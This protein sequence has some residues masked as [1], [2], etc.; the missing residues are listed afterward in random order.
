MKLFFP[1]VLAVLL[2]A[3]EFDVATIKPSAPG[4]IA[5]SF[6]S[7]PGG[8]LETAGSTLKD[9]MVIAYGDVAAQIQGGPAWAAADRYDVTA[10]V[11]EGEGD[12]AALAP[13]SHQYWSEATRQRTRALLASRFKLTV[14]KETRELPI[15]EL[16]VDKNGP[17]ATLKETDLNL[18]LS[19]RRW[20]EVAGNGA[21]LSGLVSLLSNLVQ[22]PV[23]DKTGLTARYSFTLRWAPDQ[24]STV[25]GAP[26]AEP[27][28]LPSIFTAL[29]E[30]L[31]LRLDSA[32][33]PIEVLVI[34]RAE[35]PSAD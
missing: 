3:Q 14:R 16:H 2:H 13:D 21:Y 19:Q 6:R 10:K 22:K 5:K 29:K 23:V 11:T 7:T 35:R 33:G 27:G 9:L 18:G 12:S 26:V 20:D 15:Y 32:K 24:F 8:G 28:N 25:P 1:V 17:K 4:T 30:Q 34:D 31:G